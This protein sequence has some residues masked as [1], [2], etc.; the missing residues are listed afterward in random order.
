VPSF[1]KDHVFILPQAEEYRK[2][3]SLS[4]ADVL[5]T[6]NEP[7]TQVGLATDHYTVEKTYRKHRVYVYYYLTLPLQGKQDEAY[8][9]VDFIGYT[10]SQDLAPANRSSRK[11]KEQE[12]NPSKN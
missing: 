8:A 4:I 5:A 10:A 2:F 7:D 6:L 1:T 9:I 3:Y 12:R 11:T